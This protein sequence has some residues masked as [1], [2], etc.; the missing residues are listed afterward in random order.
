VK[1][2]RPS[3]RLHPEVVYERPRARSF[4]F[5]PTERTTP[6]LPTKPP[7]WRQRGGSEVAA[8][9]APRRGSNPREGT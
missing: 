8:S 1:Q 9:P 2:F 5:R 6:T 3:R 7:A 4:D